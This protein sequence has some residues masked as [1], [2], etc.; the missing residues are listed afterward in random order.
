MIQRGDLLR[1]PYTGPSSWDMGSCDY[2]LV[3]FCLY[4]AARCT[5][6]LIL[7]YQFDVL[8]LIYWG[9]VVRFSEIV[10]RLGSGS[11]VRS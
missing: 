3:V 1:A 10:V 7:L 11:I 8:Y 4:S 2:V 5:N 6:L 9:L